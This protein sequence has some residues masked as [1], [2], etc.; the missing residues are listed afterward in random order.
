MWEIAAGLRRIRHQNGNNFHSLCALRMTGLTSGGSEGSALAAALAV[1]RP[2]GA[3]IE[4]AI[5]AIGYAILADRVAVIEEG[6]TALLWLPNSADADLGYG[7]THWC[8]GL[9]E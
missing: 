4:G 1:R 9:P 8:F 5:G 3:E 6:V 7:Q 2:A